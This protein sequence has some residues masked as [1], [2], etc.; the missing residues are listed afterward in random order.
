[1]LLRQTDIAM[2][3]ACALSKSNGQTEHVCSWTS[4][5]AGTWNHERRVV[6]KAEW[7]APVAAHRATIHASS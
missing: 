4:Y 5:A 3:V 6:C 1:M 2:Q 7:F